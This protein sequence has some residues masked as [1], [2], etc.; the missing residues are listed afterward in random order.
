MVDTH[1]AE[2]L[3]IGAHPRAIRIAAADGC[4]AKPMRRS[5]LVAMARG[6]VGRR[7]PRRNYP[8]TVYLRP[9]FNL[10]LMFQIAINPRQ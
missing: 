1:N 4:M 5:E 6:V 8:R 2:G 7:L 10:Q 9:L 3:G